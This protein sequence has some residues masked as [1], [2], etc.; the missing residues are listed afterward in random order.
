MG[1]T[2]RSSCSAIKTLSC[3]A[4]DYEGLA[5][6]DCIACARKGSTMCCRPPE[7]RPAAYE[8]A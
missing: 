4:D 7:P 5:F 6:D 2:I 8:N 1:R 3:L